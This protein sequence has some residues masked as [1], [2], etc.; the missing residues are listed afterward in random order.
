MSSKENYGGFIETDFPFVQSALIADS[1]APFPKINTSSRAVLIQLGEQ[2]WASFDTELMRVS[3][4]WNGD[5]ELNSMAQISYPYTGK[6]SSQFPKLKGH[7]LF[8]NGMA[9]G[10]SLN[11]KHM[12]NRSKPLGVHP[13]LTWKGL[14]TNEQK[15]ILSYQIQ[16]I[17]IKECLHKSSKDVYTR[18]FKTSRA[19]NLSI[20]LFQKQSLKK[21][22]KHGQIY[23]IDDA[24]KQMALHSSHGEFVLDEQGRVFLRN[25]QAKEFVLKF[26]Y[27]KDQLLEDL[28]TSN[29]ASPFLLSENLRWP[30]KVHSKAK[31]SSKDKAYVVDKIELPLK[32][33]WNRAIRLA[34]LDFF[35]DG[36]AAA[37]T[38]DG[39]V[40]IIDGLKGDMEKITWKRFASG[41]YAPLSLKVSKDQIYIL[42]RDQITRLH[43]SDANGEADFYE[44]F[45]NI[46]NH[47]LNTRNFAMDMLF[48]PEGNLYI[49]RGGIPNKKS[50]SL[51][52]SFQDLEHVGT[53]LKISPD[54]KKV[55]VFADGLREPF[56]AYNP[57]SKQ[58][59][60]NDQ[61]GHFV[62][63]SPF[64]KI[65]ECDF[66]GFQ[67]AN[68][69]KKLDLR[70]PFVWLP[71]KVEPSCAGMNFVDSST[72]GPLNQRMI[73]HSYS[74]SQSFLLYE[75]TGFGAA[76]PLPYQMDFPLLKGVL[77]PIDGSLFLSG[78]KIYSNNLPQNTGLARVRHTH[79]AVNF[80]LEV[81]VFKEAVELSFD[82]VLDSNS[83]E[84]L[85]S[86]TIKRWK[87]KRSP[88]YGS[89]HFQLDGN[90]GEENLLASRA[91][92]SKN[93]KSITL[94]IPGMTS[95]DQMAIQYRL[96]KAGKAV[97]NTLYLTLD[98]LLPM[99][100]NHYAFAELKN[101][102][103]SEAKFAISAKGK[104]SAKYGEELLKKNACIACHSL[105]GSQEGKL[106]P[107]FK[108]M[109]GSIRQFE[110]SSATKADEKFIHESLIFPNKKVAKGYAVAMASYA[111]VLSKSDIESIVLYL[112]KLK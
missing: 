10:I 9:R 82:E 111:G 84:E 58:L 90:P 36:R 97:T 59:Y 101:H 77:N 14:Y 66:C 16:D 61:Q 54:G 70:P 11:S 55:K 79:Q 74:K 109:F 46:F 104:V 71:H 49:A 62:P 25:P 22:K 37:V 27:N 33:P 32:N 7:L 4:I 56:L 35:T 96:Q 3:A 28:Q 87:Y 73:S 112:K 17:E 106:G 99:D 76:T 18:N 53:I 45:S 75:G 110:N 31:L 1:K 85:K 50:G 51:H 64:I 102:D 6:K 81:K 93:K 69:K 15:L 40:W 78:F 44:N 91:I 63:S 103:L 12:D 43:D 67:P 72:M 88:R 60:A 20:L 57:L 92:L 24:K 39:D 21:L 86:F 100:S 5:F 83:A 95:V 2:S 108:G 68:H 52:K 98:K 48:D 13:D 105:D 47:S 80:P 34:S 89:G 19:Q 94:I 8:A 65:Q 29:E 30:Q 38:F 41:L 42:G 107:S 26:S 23:L